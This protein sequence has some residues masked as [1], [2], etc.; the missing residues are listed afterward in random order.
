MAFLRCVERGK[1]DSES[2]LKS[3]IEQRTKFQ[4]EKLRAVRRGRVFDK[5]ELLEKGKGRDLALNVQQLARELGLVAVED[6]ERLGLLETGKRVLREGLESDST[7]RFLITTFLQ[8]YAAF[9]DVLL[10]VRNNNGAIVLPMARGKEIFQSESSKFG[11]R[12]GQW[13]YEIVR[14]MTTQLELLNWKR[15]MNRA[16][17]RH[18]VYLICEIV[19]LSDMKHIDKVPRRPKSFKDRCIHRFIADSKPRSVSLFREGFVDFAISKG[20]LA[21]PGL[22]DPIFL[23]RIETTEAEFDE[24][25]WSEYLILT[26]QRAMRPVYFSELRELVCERLLM[27]DTSFDKQIARIINSP[28]RYR[29]KVY[30]GGGALSHLPGIDMRRKDLPPKTG[31]GEYMT[32]LKLDRAE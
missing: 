27:S 12:C 26:K 23:K 15:E 29:T 30:A 22:R 9:R 32:Y 25:L 1:S 19:T 7:R 14:D 2:V 17:R 4:Q 8:R 24:R 13:D 21:V 31:T 11:I 16:E 3:M 5:K 20:Y 28:S 18:K 6:K 10:A